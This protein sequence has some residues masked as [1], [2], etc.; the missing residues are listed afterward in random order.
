MKLFKDIANIIQST[1]LFGP[2]VFRLLSVKHLENISRRFEDLSGKFEAVA[3]G[4]KNKGACC[5]GVE[6]LR[7]VREECLERLAQILEACWQYD[8]ATCTK[9]EC[10]E[11]LRALI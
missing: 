8:F 3:E 6:S 10:R 1:K 4:R 11:V 5:Q 7:T 2:D 9:I